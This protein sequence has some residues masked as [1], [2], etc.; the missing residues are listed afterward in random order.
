MGWFRTDVLG[1]RLCFTDRSRDLAAVPPA[2]REW[3]PI[4]QVHDT[5]VV[6]AEEV[7]AEGLEADAVVVTEPGP[8]GAVLV[9][10]CAPVA[11]VGEGGAAAV[12]VGWRGLEGGVIANAVRRLT[13]EA[14]PV[15]RAV[16][17][18]CIRP[19]CYEFGAGDLDRIAGILGDSVR[20]TT[21][22][23]AP[24]LDLP[25]GVRSALR[26]AGV[27]HLDDLGVCTACSDAYFSHRRSRDAGRQGLFVRRW[28]EN[29]S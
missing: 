5:R 19:C 16:L 6:T 18:P 29:R 9:A 23:G 25:A 7:P 21:D 27:D 26:E 15:R 28:E 4:R 1:S 14:G 12:H 13:E 17:G 20:G 24:A 2:E 3:V 10:D 22:S 8:V 11:L